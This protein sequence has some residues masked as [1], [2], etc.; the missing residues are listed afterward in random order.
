MNI[1]QK[2][3][4]CLSVAD[5]FCRIINFHYNF[6]VFISLIFLLSESLPLTAQTYNWC[7]PVKLTGGNV[8]KNP[9]F[10]KTDAMDRITS[11]NYLIFER[12]YGTNS[13]ICMIRMNNLGPMDSAFSV[14][15][16]SF[17]NI[18]PCLGTDS[19]N[20]TITHL[21][22]AWQRWNPSGNRYDLYGRYYNLYNGWS[23]I[24]TIDTSGNCE[25]PDVV[26]E[27]STRFSLVYSKNNDIILKKISAPTGAVL[28][29][30]NFTAVDTTAYRKPMI[31]KIGV[32]YTAYALTYEKRMTG[33]YFSVLG[34]S[35]YQSNPW[36]GEAQLSGTSYACENLG[37]AL[38]VNYS[39]VFVYYIRNIMP[40]YYSQIMCTEYNLQSN[41]FS[42]EYTIDTLDLNLS[43]S[44]MFDYLIIDKSQIVSAS[45]STYICD[46]NN[47]NVYARFMNG[48]NTTQNIRLGS[49]YTKYRIALSNKFTPR[50]VS[51]PYDGVCTYWGVYNRDSLTYSCLWGSYTTKVLYIENIKKT[52]SE[53]PMK[54][55]LSQN[56]PNPF[57]PVTKFRFDIARGNEVI[58]L[59][60]FDG[61]GR[62][63]KVLTDDILQPGSYEAEWDAS[64]QASGVYF[65]RMEAGITTITKK[66]VLLK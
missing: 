63:V 66:M 34:R 28:L 17:K 41:T 21:F 65:I 13:K 51:P 56:Y 24:Y 8:D 20:N 16:S 43:F 47:G 45:V 5:K 23:G 40:T 38:A 15:D 14:C 57:N 35:K 1:K 7:S 55:F 61:A 11:N 33:N 6:L 3:S 59:K 4:V 31:S 39:S 54:Y 58:K 9:R 22:F 10:N 32:Y 18:N 49:D 27:D 29:D 42:T 26:C 46:K 19:R 2:V 53:I 48:S 44:R 25:N 60:I 52:G 37:F 12:W 64:G 36:S 50:T 30:T 62:E